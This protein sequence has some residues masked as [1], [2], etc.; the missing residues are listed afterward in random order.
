MTAHNFRY[1]RGKVSTDKYWARP[2]LPNI[3]GFLNQVLPKVK[4][5]GMELWIAGKVL[6]DIANTW[7]FDCYLTGPA[8]PQIIE[9]LQHEMLSVG[10]DYDLLVDPYWASGHPTVFKDSMNQWQATDTRVWLLFPTKHRSGA[11]E[12]ITDW[13]AQPH[14]PQITEYLVEFNYGHSPVNKKHGAYLDQHGGFPKVNAQE[15]LLS[16]ADST[17]ILNN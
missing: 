6:V 14:V 4:S 10:F 12:T 1:Q 9:D 7:D 8:Q 16:L 5:Q 11:K 2:T 3:S 13:R 17:E 15:Y